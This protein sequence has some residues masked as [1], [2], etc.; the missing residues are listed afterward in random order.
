MD[1][2]AVA[3][4]LAR[5]FEGL[6]LTPYLMMVDPETDCMYPVLSSRLATRR[7]SCQYPKHHWALAA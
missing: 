2:V 5:R 7:T 6:Y 4:E 3:A 1:A